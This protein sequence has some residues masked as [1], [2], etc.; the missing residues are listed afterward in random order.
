MVACSGRVRSSPTAAW[1]ACDGDAS[2]DASK[3]ELKHAIRFSMTDKGL[4][5][6]SFVESG[7]SGKYTLCGDC[8]VVVLRA[9]LSKSPLKCEKTGKKGTIAN[10]TFI[11]DVLKMTSMKD[12]TQSPWP[13]GAA[14]TADALF[15]ECKRDIE[16]DKKPAEAMD[17]DDEDEPRARRVTE[18]F[19]EA[20]ADGDG[21]LLDKL[22]PMAR[23]FLPK[24]TLTYNV[25]VVTCLVILK[26]NDHMVS[27]PWDAYFEGQ[28][29]PR[30][31]RA[32]QSSPRHSLRPSSARPSFNTP[33]GPHGP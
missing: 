15:A 31:P 12:K 4:E 32:R 25:F 29:G 3:T 13:T 2:H 17:D 26:N 16:K 22:W 27:A 21:D 5:E 19:V 18:K 9:M 6:H 23:P 24:R 30:P 20:K 33:T 28:A 1:H 7:D 14:R 10:Q 11:N 8:A